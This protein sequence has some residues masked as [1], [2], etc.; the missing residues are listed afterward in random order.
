MAKVEHNPV[1][2]GISGAIGHLVFRQMPDGSTYVSG[3][4]DFSRRKFSQG[5]KEHQSRFQEA[6]RY[7]RNAARS[8]PIYAQLAAG[9]VL[10][11]Y[12]IALSDWFHPP[13]IHC[14][15]R[16]GMT[17]RVQATDNVMVAGVSVTILDER[18]EIKEKG[19]AV[20]EKGIRAEGIGEGEWWEYTATA[21]GRMAVEARDLAGNVVRAEISE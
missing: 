19:E 16:Q 18:G 8:Q 14:V 6:V 12:N 4:H 2:R 1:V 7:A 9:T 10:S 15:E 13:V 5:Q 17:I 20:R 11:P 3:K 21:E